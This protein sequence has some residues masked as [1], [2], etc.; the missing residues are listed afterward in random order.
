MVEPCNEKAAGNLLRI[1]DRRSGRGG[2]FGGLTKM[3]KIYLNFLTAYFDLY[4]VAVLITK[5]LKLF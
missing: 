2:H 3:I 5:F 1:A 4:G